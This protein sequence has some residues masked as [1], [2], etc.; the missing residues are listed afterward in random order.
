ML[1]EDMGG[2]A[3]CLSAVHPQA[4]PEHSLHEQGCYQWSALHESLV[5]KKGVAQSSFFFPIGLAVLQG[6]ESVFSFLIFEMKDTLSNEKN[7]LQ[8]DKTLRRLRV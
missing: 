2:P 5:L 4:L 1:F 8:N 6:G 7:R 3:A